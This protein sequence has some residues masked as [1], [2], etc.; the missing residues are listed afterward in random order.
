MTSHN[1]KST[2]LPPPPPSPPP[3]LFSIPATIFFFPATTD[4]SPKTEA[5]TVYVRDIDG[6]KAYVSALAKSGMKKDATPSPVPAVDTPTAVPEETAV[7][8]DVAAN[9]ASAT[10]ETTES[11]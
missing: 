11:N 4:G 2:L 10:S 8:V 9:G 6:M 1:V 5:L 7:A 3:L